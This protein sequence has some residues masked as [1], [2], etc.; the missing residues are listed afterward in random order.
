MIDSYKMTRNR[1]KY[2]W[3]PVVKVQRRPARGK[4]SSSNQSHIVKKGYPKM[5][6]KYKWTFIILRPQLSTR[7]VVGIEKCITFKGLLTL[8]GRKT[9]SLL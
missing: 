7:I 4:V 3:E 2:I 6:L 1:F 5:I 9:I 8:N